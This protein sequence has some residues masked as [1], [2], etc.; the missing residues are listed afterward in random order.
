ML[1]GGV[2]DTTVYQRELLKRAEDRDDVVFA[3][4]LKGEQLAELVRGA[5]LFTLPS[6]LEGLPLAMLEAMRE[7]IPILASDILAHRQ[8]LGTDRG[9][10]FQAGN[11]QSCIDSIDAALRDLE[12]LSQMAKRAKKHVS[13]NYTWQKITAD[14]LDLYSALLSSD[15]PLNPEKSEPLDVK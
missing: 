11:L 10:M 2:S 7:G 15:F 1:V 6:D 8:L 5:G 4:E 3:G 9:I 14:N 13:E 12:K